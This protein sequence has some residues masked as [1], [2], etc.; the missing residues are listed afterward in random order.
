MTS[1]SKKKQSAH[2]LTSLCWKL[3]YLGNYKAID[4]VSLFNRVIDLAVEIVGTPQGSTPSKVYI[5]Q[6]Y[7][8][9]KE[10]VSSHSQEVTKAKRERKAQRFQPE[11][12]QRVV[13]VASDAFLGTY[14]WRRVRMVALKK[15]GARCQ[16]CGASPADGAVMNVD[17]I[18]PRKLFPELALDVNNLQILC[19]ECNHGKGNWDMTDWREAHNVSIDHDAMSHIPSII[20]E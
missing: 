9:L 5:V 4:H 6:N 7:E 1:K 14:E 15:Y 16:C 10:Y 12:T 11:K 3:F 17:H 18:K 20:K 8:K 2:R 19:H 13:G